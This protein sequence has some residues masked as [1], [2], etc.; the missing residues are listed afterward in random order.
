MAYDFSD[1]SSFEHAFTT[2]DANTVSCNPSDETLF[3]AGGGLGGN[4]RVEFLQYSY[5]DKNITSLKQI[6]AA[7]TI[8]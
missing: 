6:T 2:S 3:F 4:F 5:T 7:G 8:V 1:N